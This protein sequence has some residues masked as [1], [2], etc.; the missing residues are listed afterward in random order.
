MLRLNK[1]IEL[2]SWS[3]ELSFVVKNTVITLV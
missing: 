2:C 1:K 3:V